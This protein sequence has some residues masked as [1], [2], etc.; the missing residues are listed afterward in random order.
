MI[1]VSWKFNFGLLYSLE[2]I[3]C[4]LVESVVV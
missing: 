2:I 1:F 3:I 4:F